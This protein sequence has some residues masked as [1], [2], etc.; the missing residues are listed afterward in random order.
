[1]AARVRMAGGVVGIAQRREGGGKAGVLNTTFDFL[2]VLKDL[3]LLS[4][5]TASWGLVAPH[6]GS[7]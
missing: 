4:T 7:E 6:G 5:P 3:G 1:M 2:W